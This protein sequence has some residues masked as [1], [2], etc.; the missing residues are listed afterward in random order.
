MPQV[1]RQTHLELLHRKTGSRPA[2]FL[3]RRATLRRILRREVSR[4]VLNE[5]RIGVA[6]PI[7]GLDPLEQVDPLPHG[8]TPSNLDRLHTVLGLAHDLDVRFVGQDHFDALT[9]D[10][11]VIGQEHADLAILDGR[12]RRRCD[13]VAALPAGP[14]PVA[15]RSPAVTL[16]LSHHDLLKAAARADKAVSEEAEWRLLHDLWIDPAA[17]K[18]ST[19]GGVV[20]IAGEVGTWSEAELVKRWVARVE[21]AV[22]VDASALRYRLDDHYIAPPTASLDA[23][24]RK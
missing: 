14:H 10:H 2:R 15:A 1:F 22:D 12:N 8:G 5:L 21:G 20:T 4:Q 17:L 9:D 24:P 23:P 19:H 7:W 3:R 13:S 6:E 16:A 11:M 18:I